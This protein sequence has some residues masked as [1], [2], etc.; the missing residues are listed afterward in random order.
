MVRRSCPHSLCVLLLAACQFDSSGSGFPQGASIAEGPSPTSS[1]ADD[2]DAGDDGDDTTSVGDAPDAMTSGSLPDDDR[3]TTGDA[4]TTGDAPQLPGAEDAASAGDEA[5]ATDPGGDA[6]AQDESDGGDVDDGGE[7]DGADVCPASFHEVY[8]MVD[9]DVS[10]PMTLVPT[11]GHD[12]PEA[13]VSLVENDGEVTVTIDLPC[14]GEY[15]VWGLVWDYDPGAWASPDPDSLYVDFG[16][17]E[18]IWRYG[19]QT[20]N[21][22]SG[23]SWQKLSVLTAQPCDLDY[24]VVSAAAA[25][26]YAIRFRNREAGEGSAVAGIAAIAVSLDPAADPGAL[27]EPY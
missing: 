12:Q 14:A 3:G 26:S 18:S 24:L 17:G 8:W 13:A 25:G 22:P 1:D 2:G 20:A 7:V 9:G 11:D 5:T 4:S 23:L 21:S 10:A 16:G 6:G 15:T 19:C 27:Y